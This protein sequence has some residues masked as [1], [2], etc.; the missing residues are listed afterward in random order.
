MKSPQ[1]YYRVHTQI[2]FLFVLRN[3]KSGDKL[4]LRSG[5]ISDVTKYSGTVEEGPKGKNP[6]H[7]GKIFRAT[8]GHLN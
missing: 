3:T 6:T 8:K 4:T 7:G 1:P 2:F 5:T